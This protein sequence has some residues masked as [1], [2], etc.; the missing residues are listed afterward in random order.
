LIFSAGPDIAPVIEGLLSKAQDQQ[1]WALKKL[2]L[3]L[4][5]CKRLIDEE[6]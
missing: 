5:L 4:D 1:I 6:R 3:D 2:R